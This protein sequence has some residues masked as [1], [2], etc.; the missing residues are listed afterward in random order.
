MY[1]FLGVTENWAALENQPWTIRWRFVDD[2]REAV[3]LDGVIFSGSVVTPDGTQELQIEKSEA[4]GEENVV[5][6]SC[7]GLPEGRH[8]YEVWTESDSGEKNRMLSGYI[9]VIPSAAEV[10]EEV[11]S[12]LSRTLEVRV[13]NEGK[14]KLKLEWLACSMAAQSALQAW[15]YLDEIRKRFAELEQMI[16]EAKKAGKLLEGLEDALKD[17]NNLINAAIE[18]T[19]PYV[20]E[21]GNWWRRVGERAYD[22]GM[23]AVGFDGQ[24]GRD[25]IDGAPG[26]DGVDGADGQ[27]G[28]D[29]HSPQ[30]RYVNEEV[31]G[32]A[33]EGIYWYD[34]DD[35]A[36][37]WVFTKT[38]AEGR[39]GAPGRDADDFI[40]LLLEDVSQLPEDGNFGTICYVKKP[41]GDEGYNTY[42]WLQRPDGTADWAWVP[43]ENLADNYMLRDFANAQNLAENYETAAKDGEIPTVGWVKKAMAAVQSVVTQAVGKLATLSVA[44]VIKLSSSKT[45]EKGGAIGLNAAG[46]ALVVPAGTTN[47]GAVKLSTSAVQTADGAAVVGATADGNLMVPKAGYRRLGTVMMGT[48]YDIKAND[49]PHCVAIPYFNGDKTY[50]KNAGNLDGSM[51]LNLAIGSCLKYTNS[52]G[53]NGENKSHCLWVDHDESLSVQEG[54]KLSAKEWVANEFDK[55]NPRPITSEA[56]EKYL[57]S[58]GYMKKTEVDNAIKEALK[59]YTSGTDLDNKLKS[60]VTSS[61][62][63]TTLKNYVET[64]SLN[65]LLEKNKYVTSTNL[66]TKLKDYVIGKDGI[67]YLQQ[68]TQTAFNALGTKQTNTYYIIVN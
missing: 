57:A 65:T 17:A 32:V 39:D 64:T 46:Q 7:P 36:Q 45:P 14:K 22:L 55:T 29:G 5:I 47:Y 8:Y 51:G 67:K 31:D 63:N 43:S 60:Y 15:E 13:S 48:A 62:L 4:E 10:A 11:M 54:G 25:G 53:L 6:L 21:N 40:R 34:W 61:S 24:D 38:R 19:I 49:N 66:D 35:E 37:E 44:G 3:S 23:R 2:G 50:N 18:D 42:L 9:G 26:R 52:S 27:D 12:Y 16:E 33:Y 28:K 58:M 20:G 1:D 59:A 56:L 30:L 41:D 68:I